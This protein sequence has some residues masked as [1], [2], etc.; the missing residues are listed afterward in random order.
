MKIRGIELRVSPVNAGVALFFGLFLLYSYSISGSST[1]LVFGIPML[2]ALFLIPILLNYMSQEQYAELLPQYQRDAKTVRI[3]AI[4]MNMLGEPVRFEGV[5][6]QVHF[7]YLN[8]PSFLVGDKSGEISVKMFT[9]PQENIHKGDMVEVIGMV[10]KRYIMGGDPVVNC[11][12]IRKI[13][14]TEK[15]AEKGKNS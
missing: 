13:K 11:V 9:S 12:S 4:N 8:R 15:P 1:V 2:L 10:I 14:T 7:W 3:K 5:V 6:E